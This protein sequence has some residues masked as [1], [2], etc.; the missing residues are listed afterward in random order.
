MGEI[1]GIGTTHYPGLA[2]TDEGMSGLWQLIINAPLIDQKW[3]DKSNWPAGMLDEVGNDM[4]LSAA[5]RYRERMWRNFREQRRIID[6]FKPDF[7][8][9]IA[10]VRWSH[11][12]GQFGGEVKVYSVA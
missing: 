2:A 12:V 7:I 3:K 1:L 10:D 11:I 9:L 4:G 5:Q 8:V 6:E